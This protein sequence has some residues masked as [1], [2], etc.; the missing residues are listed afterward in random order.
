MGITERAVRNIIADLS[1]AGYIEKKR[2]GRRLKYT[3]NPSLSL[4]QVAHQDIAIGDL[5]ASLGW[6]REKQGNQ[7]YGV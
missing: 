2:E 1:D 4:R 3:I 7:R 5:L 6:Q